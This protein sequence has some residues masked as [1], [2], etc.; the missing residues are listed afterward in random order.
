MKCKEVFSGPSTWNPAFRCNWFDPSIISQRTQTSPFVLREGIHQL[1]LQAWDTSRKEKR[2]PNS[3]EEHLVFWLLLHVG[4]T[5]K[6]KSIVLLVASFGGRLCM[7]HGTTLTYL[8]EHREMEGRGL[9]KGTLSAFLEKALKWGEALTL[10]S[11]Q[12]WKRNSRRKDC[13]WQSIHFDDCASHV[14]R[15]P[16]STQGILFH[17]TFIG[18]VCHGLNLLLDDTTKLA[19]HQRIPGRARKLL[20]NMQKPLIAAE[21]KKTEETC[22]EAMLKLCC[23][24][25]SERIVCSLIT[26]PEVAQ[27]NA[28]ASFEEQPNLFYRSSPL[29]LFIFVFSSL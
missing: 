4:R 23:K 21:F 25:C 10:Q 13:F 8:V 19:F 15:L 26:F 5:L 7:G 9:R 28:N 27:H 2:D 17:V 29:Q 22:R 18:C 20:W 6:N 1:R 24:T 3:Y 11:W 12:L 16:M 14:G